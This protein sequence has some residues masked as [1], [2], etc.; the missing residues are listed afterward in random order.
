MQSEQFNMRINKLSQSKKIKTSLKF[1]NK[2]LIVGIVHVR[3]ISENNKTI[4]MNIEN[5]YISLTP[6]D[7]QFSFCKF[8]CFI[9][10][11]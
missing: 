10:F 3:Y 7:T 6:D 5:K 1:I 9:I 11:I 4:K 2:N 8:S